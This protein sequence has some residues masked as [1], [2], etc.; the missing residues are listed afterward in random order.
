MLADAYELFQRTWMMLSFY[1]EDLIS[2]FWAVRVLDH[3]KLIEPEP[4]ALFD[5]VCF[6]FDLKSWVMH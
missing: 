1:I 3:Y 2:F 6:G 5:L 4:Q